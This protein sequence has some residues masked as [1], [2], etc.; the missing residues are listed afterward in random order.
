MTNK[1]DKQKP[2]KLWPTRTIWIVTSK[3]YLDYGKQTILERWQTKANW[4]LTIRDHLNYD[5]Q[6]SCELWK[7]GINWSIF[8]KRKP[9]V[10]RQTNSIKHD[11]QGSSK[12]WQ[13]KKHL[14]YDKQKKYEV[15]KTGNIWSMT[16]IWHLQDKEKLFPVWHVRILCTVTR[17]NHP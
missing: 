13:R 14:N 17:R 2:S 10:L 5:K 16:D 12:V 1:K 6:A 11:K 3:N 4:T 9:S 8:D 7:T 15:W